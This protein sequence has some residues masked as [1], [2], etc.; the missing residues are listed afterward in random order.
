[1]NFYP[2]GYHMLLRDHAVGAYTEDIAEW[3]DAITQQIHFARTTFTA[4]DTANVN[5]STA[6]STM[7]C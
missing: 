3:I 5:S 7:S 2:D 6:S 1:M 4:P